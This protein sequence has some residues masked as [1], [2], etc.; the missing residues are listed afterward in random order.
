MRRKM[1]F[2]MMEI[3]LAI[4]SGLS[5]FGEIS[6]RETGSIRGVIADE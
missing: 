3:F 1:L 5:L 6:S 2:L 4:S